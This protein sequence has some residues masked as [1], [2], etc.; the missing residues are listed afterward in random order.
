MMKKKKKKVLVAKRKEVSPPIIKEPRSC[1]KCKEELSPERLKFFPDGVICAG[2]QNAEK[3]HDES[4][5]IPR[6]WVANILNY[7]SPRL[8]P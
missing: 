2:C 5:V 3:L 8:K 7:Y 1:I 4:I 6:K